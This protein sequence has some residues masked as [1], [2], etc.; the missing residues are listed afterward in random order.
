MVVIIFLLMRPRAPMS[1]RT[2]TLVP[3]TTL[4]RSH[5]RPPEF[6]LAM[7][8]AGLRRYSA[9]PGAGW[10]A[11]RRNQPRYLAEVHPARHAGSGC[12]PGGRVGKRERFECRPMFAARPSEIG[13]AHV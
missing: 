8:R 7:L 10:T 5:D 6:V 1:T 3:Y 4:F 2:G 12:D 11:G 9:R 13:R